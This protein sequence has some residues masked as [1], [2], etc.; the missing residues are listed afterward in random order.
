MSRIFRIVAQVHYVGIGNSYFAQVRSCGS[1]YMIVV[2]GNAARV[3]SV[4]GHLGRLSRTALTDGDVSIVI[5]VQ[6]D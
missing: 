1:K 2:T 4:L 5:A 6:D 3:R